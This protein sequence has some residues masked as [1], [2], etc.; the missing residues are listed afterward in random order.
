M[1]ADFQ[2]KLSLQHQQHQQSQQN[3]VNNNINN[4]N[5]NT[6]PLNDESKL[7]HNNT[8][9]SSINENDDSYAATMTGGG[10]DIYSAADQNYMPGTASLIGE[11]DKQLMV[12]LRDGRCLIGYLRSID[13]YANLLLSSCVERVHVGNKYGDIQR[14]N[15]DEIFLNASMAT[16]AK[17]ARFCFFVDALY[18]FLFS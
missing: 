16:A 1:L 17:N 3:F 18:F 12:V 10:G 11:V 13:Q 2:A 15:S 7:S 6:N 5:N 9:D 14:G 4:M 8:F